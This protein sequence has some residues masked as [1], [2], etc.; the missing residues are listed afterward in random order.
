MKQDLSR[1]FPYPASSGP[2][3]RRAARTRSSSSRPVWLGPGLYQ[4]VQPGSVQAL[5]AVSQYA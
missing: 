5:V 3:T 2:V 1:V 4:V